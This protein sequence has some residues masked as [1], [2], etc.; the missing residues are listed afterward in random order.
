MPS[1]LER[2]VPSCYS[3]KSRLLFLEKHEKLNTPC[4]QNAEFLYVSVGGKQSL[5][6]TRV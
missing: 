5:I 1:P 3:G 2:P 6:T 4:K